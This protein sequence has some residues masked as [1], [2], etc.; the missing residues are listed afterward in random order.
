MLKTTELPPRSERLVICRVNSGG[1]FPTGLVE[2][3][4]DYW[5]MAA[6]VNTPD[7]RGRVLVRCLNPGEESIIIPAG[8]GVGTY[9]GIQPGC[10][11]IQTPTSHTSTEKVT[12]DTVT[13]IIPEHVKQLADGAKKNCSQPQYQAVDKLL[14]TYADVFSR[15]DSD[16]GLTNLVTHDIPFAPGTR[17]IRQHPRRLGHEKEKR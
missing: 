6:S 2:G 8:T 5:Q 17:P 10:D 13:P 16:T 1:I 3:G 15:D 4:G 7:H 12:E 9:L 14:T 11:L